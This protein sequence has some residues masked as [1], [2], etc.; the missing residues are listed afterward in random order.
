MSAVTT[1]TISLPPGPRWTA[2]RLC[3]VLALLLVATL[4]AAAASGAVNIP[5]SALPGLLLGVPDTPD[6]AMWHSV[7]WQ[8]RLPR[9]L[10]AVLVGG[11][12]ALAGAAMQALF[13]NPLAE[14]GLVGI[15]AG[16]ALG[17]VAAIV[18]GG[19]NF[20]LMAPAAFV[21]SLLA[22]LIAYRLGRIGHGMDSILLAGVAINAICWAIIG[23][24]TYLA[25]D[26]QLRTLTFWN[27][28]SLAGATWPLLAFLG[29]WT[30]LICALLLRD[31]R[32]MNALLLGERE[33]HHLGF[34]LKPL[35]RR[36]IVLTALLVGPL[37]A[38]TGTIGFVGLVVPH[39]VRLVLG[40][41]HRGLLPTAILAGA[42]ALAL[43]DW[44]ARTVVI[45]SEL[46][47]GVVTS[48]IGGP[49][50][51]WLLTRGGAR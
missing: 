26:A 15:S 43:A 50:F 34:A 29:P 22:T 35:R 33:A 2:P 4:L 23:L 18:L 44:L 36:L 14:P 11:G 19:A 3:A 28:G 24:F 31:W 46:P 30:V 32:A 38:A 41:D 13:R 1:P 42:L 39:L 7:L 25:N 51:L 16:G 27:L 20:T 5:L 49:F 6:G 9:V 10:F 12:L 45:P 17:A 47:I 40:A 37:V 8:V 48:L 21:G